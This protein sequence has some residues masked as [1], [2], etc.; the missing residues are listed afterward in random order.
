M[1]IWKNIEDYEGFYQCSNYGRIKINKDEYVEDI[2]KLD[3]SAKQSK[4]ELITC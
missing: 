4:H 2:E 3:E 1:E